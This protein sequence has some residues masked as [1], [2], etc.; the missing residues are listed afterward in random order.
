MKWTVGIDLGGTNIAVGLVDEQYEIV[1]RE[2]VK[3]RAPRSA[4]SLAASMARCVNILLKRHGLRADQLTAIGIGV[5]GVVDP[6]TKHLLYASNLFLKHVDLVSLVQTHLPD[7]PILVGNDA[8]C[9]AYGEY[10]A[11]E[12]KLY[13]SALML[14]LGTGIGGGFVCDGKIFRGGTGFGIEP[15]HLVVDLQEGVLCS[16]GQSGC[17]EAYASIRGLKRLVEKGLANGEPS[18][19]RERFHSQDPAFNTRIVF[20]AV[21]KGDAVALRVL[22][23]YVNYLAVGIRTLVVLYRPHIILLGGGISNAGNLLLKP[24]R[25]AVLR[26]TFAGDIIAPPPIHVSRLGN[27]AGIIGAAMLYKEPIV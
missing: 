18:M 26:T 19:M 20:D 21:R 17:L 22:E 12:A 25:A 7:V 23:Q 6:Q 1:G 8:D 3:T 9:A 16:C 10:L 14:T 4:S 13:D 11:G 24:L 27:D 2:K 15:G 5:P